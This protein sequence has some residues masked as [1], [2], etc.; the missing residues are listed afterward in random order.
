VAQSGTSDR[1]CAGERSGSAAD[2]QP[3]GARVSGAKAT[4]RE[5][6]WVNALGRFVDWDKEEP[7]VV[8]AVRFAFG[9]NL[10]IGWRRAPR[11]VGR[12]AKLNRN[13][14]AREACGP[15]AVS[16]A[17]NAIM[18][19]R[20]EITPYRNRPSPIPHRQFIRI[21]G[22]RTLAAKNL[23]HRHPGHHPRAAPSL[24]CRRALSFVCETQNR[25][26]TVESI[27]STTLR[28]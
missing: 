8:R 5:T 18:R 21:F 9:F 15:G 1:A 28:R 16:I 7:L 3:P 10:P 14:T 17:G 20:A 19:T 12:H 13:R 6:D 26:A 4:A 24:P 22:T 2:V 23:E 27:A 11:L 25:V